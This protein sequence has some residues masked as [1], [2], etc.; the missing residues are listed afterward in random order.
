MPIF[1][2]LKLGTTTLPPSDVVDTAAVAGP[3]FINVTL[4]REFVADAVCQLVRQGPGEGGR[5]GDKERGGPCSYQAPPVTCLP[6]GVLAV[7]YIAEMPPCLEVEIRRKPHIAQ[8]ALEAKL[9]RITEPWVWSVSVA[10][11]VF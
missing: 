9:G 1:K 10:L 11:R 3:G 5:E 4:K 7:C 8:L 2:K 6:E